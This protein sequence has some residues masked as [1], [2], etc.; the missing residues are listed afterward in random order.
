MVTFSDAVKLR[1]DVLPTELDIYKH[2]L[3]LNSLKL[4]TGD[5]VTNTPLSKKVLHV[6]NDV[7]A[8]WRRTG[9]PFDLDGF[10]G[11][12]RILNLVS[13]GRVLNKV[14][15]DRRAEDFGKELNILFDVAPCKHPDDISC[16]CSPDH[17]VPPTWR[18]FLTDQRGVRQIQGVLSEG[19]LTLRHAHNREREKK[20][21]RE[22]VR[23]KVEELE[24]KKKKDMDRRSKELEE[25][26][27]LFSKV[28]IQ[29]ADVE[30]GDEEVNENEVEGPSDDSDW[31]DIDDVPEK[32]PRRN[33]N[34]VSLNIC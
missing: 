14:P 34:T 15:H 33:Y 8:L 31:E 29:P 1:G 6:M 28:P 7:A 30:L 20:E 32:V 19:A 26:D 24:R 5:W 22:A 2:Y 21:S 27:I 13:K 11:E 18:Q 23:Y 16:I 17:K 10:K 4:E 3:Y 12:R 9:I 25:I